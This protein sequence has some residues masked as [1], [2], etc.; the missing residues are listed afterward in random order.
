M[1]YKTIN[2]NELGVILRKYFET[3]NA[4]I[5]IVEVGNFRNQFNP[6]KCK[7]GVGGVCNII[8]ETSKKIKGATREKSSN[9]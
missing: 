4:F 7:I 9:S 5:E 8:F 3:E 6:T 1:Y 2:V